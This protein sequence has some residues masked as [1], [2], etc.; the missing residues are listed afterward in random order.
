VRMLVTDFWEQ[1]YLP[2]ITENKCKSTVDGYVQVWNKFLKDHVAGWFLDDYLPSDG[3]NY[4]LELTRKGYGLRTINHAR[5]LASGIWGHAVSTGKAQKNPWPD[6]EIIGKVAQ[7]AERPHYTQEEA[8]KVIAALAPRTECQLIMALACFAGLRQGEI[9]GLR[10]EHIRDGHAHLVQSFV[11]GKVGD[12]KS[13][14]SKRSVPIIRP[15]AVLLESWWTASGKPTT[16]WIFPN[17][18]GD[19]PINLRDRARNVIKPALKKAG[20]EWKGYHAGRHCFGQLLT[21]LTGNALAARDGL[22]HTTTAITEQFYLHKS[23]T[24]LTAGMKQLEA[25]IDGE[26]S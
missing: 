11:R 20:V 2:F 10:W 9:A 14:R 7:P 5:Y 22:G 6:A 16:G 4:L 26:Q 24:A 17:P 13:K 15:V 1:H 12:L 18:T 23:Q 25:A 19:Q 21:D 8:I 3:T